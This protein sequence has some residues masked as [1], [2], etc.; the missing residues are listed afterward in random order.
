MR[1][2]SLGSGFDRFL[3]RYIDRES[4]SLHALRLELAHRLGQL[5]LIHVGQRQHRSGGCQLFRNRAPNAL[6]P[7]C[8]QCNS[9]LQICHLS[10]QPLCA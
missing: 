10:S 7:A 6:R 3:A 2:I 5:C 1:S 4:R 9:S 8:N